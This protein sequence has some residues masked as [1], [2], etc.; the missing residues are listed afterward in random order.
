M[1]SDLRKYLFE[2]IG[3]MFLVL[4]FSMSGSP[5]ATG[6]IFAVLVYLGKEVSGGNYNPAISLAMWMRGKLKKVDMWF[7]ILSQVMGGF[8]AALIYFVISTKRYYPTP[9]AWVAYWKLFMLEV[10]FT[11]F[12]CYVFLTVMTSK[13]FKGE[14]T[15]SLMVGLALASIV[16]LG[17]TFNPAISI[18]PA[19][20][21][22]LSMG[23]SFI[24]SLKYAPVNVLGAFSG[25]A[26][27]AV[28]FNYL[29][30]DETV[31]KTTRRKKSTT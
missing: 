8:F 10:T 12:L 22:F 28:A 6:A 5:I 7:Y 4:V 27:A 29:N 25:G 11:F 24:T 17:V 30:V 26:L 19:A 31:K 23:D 18:G 9:L 21:D 20:F 1:R 15:N 2:G 14:H 13:K 3:T 16:F